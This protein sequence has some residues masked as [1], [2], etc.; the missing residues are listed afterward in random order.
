MRYS[1]SKSFDRHRISAC[2]TLRTPFPK[3]RSAWMRFDFRERFPNPFDQSAPSVA[4]VQLRF[5]AL[6]FLFFQSRFPCPGTPFQRGLRKEHIPAVQ[7]HARQNRLSVLKDLVRCDTL[8][9]A[10]SAFRDASLSVFHIVPPEMEYPNISSAKAAIF[11]ADI[12]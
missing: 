12:P 7:I 10:A 2:S 4:D 11:A 3:S 8:F 9:S 5:E 6:L 1:K